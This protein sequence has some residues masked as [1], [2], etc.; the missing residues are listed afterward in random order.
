MHSSDCLAQGSSRNNTS[1]NH[2]GS[3]FGEE[4][5]QTSMPSCM[6]KIHKNYVWG[7]RTVPGSDVC[8]RKAVCTVC[9]R[10]S[11][12]IA[13]VDRLGNVVI[14]GPSAM[15][16]AVMKQGG[17][18]GPSVPS[19][20]NGADTLASTAPRLTAIISEAYMQPQHHHQRGTTNAAAAHP[21]RW[22]TC[23][24]SAASSSGWG[25]H[26]STVS[27][28]AGGGGGS[29]G[30]AGTDGKYTFMDEEYLRYLQTHMKWDRDGEIIHLMPIA[31]VY[32]E[33]LS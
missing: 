19:C 25:A 2:Y 26:S 11:S 6:N 29:G 7:S 20:P 30:A 33:D 12:N 10:L 8:N 24:V 13:K 14:S 32:Q 16:L 27:A 23:S 5:K 3:S 9:N 31:V 1:L 22:D 15:E 28:G 17:R 18:A 21:S 4:I